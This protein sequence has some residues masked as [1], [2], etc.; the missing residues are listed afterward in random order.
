MS[1]LVQY[2]NLLVNL[3]YFGAFIENI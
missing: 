3:T 1:K 2:D